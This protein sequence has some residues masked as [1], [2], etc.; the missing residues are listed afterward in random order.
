M[1]HAAC[2]LT[3]ADV[4][5]VVAVAIAFTVAA[6]AFGALDHVF[7]G[8]PQCFVVVKCLIYCRMLN[9]F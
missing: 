4:A 1:L 8:S 2:L 6:S 3:A 9:I 5:A 7:C